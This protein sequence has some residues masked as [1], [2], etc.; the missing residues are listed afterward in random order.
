MPQL[1]GLD[2]LRNLKNPPKIILTTAY[3][4]YAV[5]SYEL[6]VLDYL[7]KPI[8]FDRF[9]MSID[10]FAS[11]NQYRTELEKR[12]IETGYMILKT[13]SD[14]VKVSI[15]KILFVESFKDRIDIQTHEKK[16]TIKYQIG[17]FEKR[18]NKYSF[19][20]IHKSFIIIE[21]YNIL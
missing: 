17:E 10:K 9:L 8:T 14:H 18:L 16:Y 2:F 20:R 3:R 6:D 7:L 5:E 4:E 11:S 13:G 21:E 15:N 19:R 12:P 1:N